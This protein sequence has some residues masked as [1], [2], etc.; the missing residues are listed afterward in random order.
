LVT[1]TEVEVAKDLMTARVFV[2][3]L[4][5][6]DDRQAAL[7]ALDAARGFIRH[8]LRDNL[9]LRPI[10]DLQFVSD[11]SIE[12]GARVTALLNKLSASKAENA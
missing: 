5:T 8:A 11:T 1:I 4:G 2:S 7:T 9:D 3:V 6:Q 10:P 12:E